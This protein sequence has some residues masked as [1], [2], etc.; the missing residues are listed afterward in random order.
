MLIPIFPILK[1]VIMIEKKA[2]FILSVFVF[3]GILLSI[4]FVKAQQNESIERSW[5]TTSQYFSE[6]LKNSQI[7]GGALV[8]LEKGEIK[9]SNYYGYAD[10]D[11]QRKVDENTIF[12]GAS[13]TKTFTAI[14]IMQL[15]DRGLLSLSDPITKYLPEIRKVYNP[16]GSMDD[17]TIK[18]ILSHSAGFRNPT[19]PWG[20]SEA[21]HPFEPT[22]WS[23]LV[24]MLPYTKIL[25]QPGSKFSYSNPAIIFLGRIIE[26]LSGDDYEI[27]IDKN[28]LKPLKMYNSYYDITPY[29]LIKYRANNYTIQ[30][31]T[32]M[33]NGL[34]FDTGITTSNGGLNAPIS[35]MLKYLNFLTGQSEEYEILKRSSLEEL[36]QVQH[37]IEEIDKVKSSIALSFFIEEFEGMQVIGHTG[38]QKSFYSFFYF[39]PISATA[40]IGITNTDGAGEKPNPDKLRVE[41]SHYVFRHLFKFYQ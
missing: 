31:G 21:W 38:T 8:F 18:M 25:F 36:W 3:G 1:P 10:L 15:R 27:Y 33:D 5:K 17:I 41:I 7:V 35:D 14:G 30:D 39:H 12:H 37:P 26:I 2:K 11:T 19:W 22:E 13:I 40:C 6:T 24:A 9:G 20:G 23:Q 34:D 16:Y 29:H 4:H 28:I 32:P